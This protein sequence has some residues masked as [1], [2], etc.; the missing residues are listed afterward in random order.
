MTMPFDL[1]KLPAEDNA[2]QQEVED[3]PAPDVPEMD[4]SA[5]QGFVS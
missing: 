1:N 4:A 2:F 3:A 5:E